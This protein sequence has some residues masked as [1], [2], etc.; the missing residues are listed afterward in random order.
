[1]NLKSL[2]MKFLSV[3]VCVPAVA[4]TYNADFG[5]YKSG[6]IAGQTSNWTI[7]GGA[8]SDWQIGQVDGQVALRHVGEGEGVIY[9]NKYACS[10]D[11]ILT[12]KIRLGAEGIS[13][14]SGVVFGSDG[15]GADAYHQWRAYFADNGAVTSGF[16]TVTGRITDIIRGKWMSFRLERRG[17]NIRLDYS[18]L[19]KPDYSAFL[20]EGTLPPLKS[21]ATGATIG[22]LGVG[23][24]AFADISLSFPE[25]ITP[26]QASVELSSNNMRLTVDTRTGLPIQLVSMVPSPME[27]L[28]TKN[29]FVFYIA[30]K[31]GKTVDIARAKSGIQ[32]LGKLAFE[33]TPSDP[34]MQN[35]Y[36][37]SVTYSLE[38]NSIHCHAELTALKD[39]AG[40]HQIRFAFGL[41]PKDYDYLWYPGIPHD[42]TFA[43]TDGGFSKFNQNFG[44]VMDK[45]GTKNLFFGTLPADDIQKASDVP[46]AALVTPMTV[47]ER[48]ERLVA[49]AHFDVGQPFLLA[50]DAAGGRG[51]YPMIL[52]FP[53]NIA[54]GQ[55]FVFDI[56]V[57]TFERPKK[58]Y[59]QVMRW[60]LENAY[61]TNPN[62]KDV[63]GLGKIK[64]GA[65]AMPSGLNCSG[66]NGQ[67]LATGMML[68]H[69]KDMIE[70]GMAMPFW[71]CGMST[72]DELYPLDSRPY[73]DEIGIRWTKEEVRTEIKRISDAGM[74][75][76][77]YRRSWLIWETCKDDRIPYKK[78]TLNPE[79]DPAKRAIEI[80]KLTPDEVKVYGFDTVH[81]VQA[82]FSNNDF[83]SWYV[84]QVIKELGYY[85]P[86][87]IWWDM[88]DSGQ[89]GVMDAMT[90]IRNK[91]A[92][93]YPWMRFVGNERA[94]TVDGLQCDAMAVESYEISGKTERTFQCAKAFGRSVYNLIYSVYYQM[95]GFILPKENYHSDVVVVNDVTYFAITYRTSSL[96]TKRDT[97]IITARQIS[98][99]DG[100]PAILVSAKDLKADGKWHTLYVPVAGKLSGAPR[101]N[102]IA[103]G[104]EDKMKAKDEK[105][106][107]VALFVN[108]PAGC[109]LD[110]S[111]YGFYASKPA[112]GDLASPRGANS[113][114]YDN[115]KSL[116]NWQTPQPVISK[117]GYARFSA[118]DKQDGTWIKTDFRP[119]YRGFAR[120]L[121]LGA[122]PGHGPAE[123]NFSMLHPLYDFSN[124]AS[125][126][127][128]VL[129]PMAAWPASAGVKAS[130]WAGRHRI[131][132]AAYNTDRTPV[133]VSIDIDLPLL[134][135]SYGFT[136]KMD[137][138]S[139]SIFNADLGTRAAQGFSIRRSDDGHATVTGRLGSNELMLLYAR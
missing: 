89:S 46:W 51:T 4:G 50:M 125:K 25:P 36:K 49:F 32:D 131:L 10:G 17:Q 82:D 85:Q 79:V 110:V 73:F 43:P 42:N 44:P 124:V 108:L 114:A 2:S 37:A 65:R 121:A 60:F 116:L 14:Y 129:E 122:F 123:P 35:T 105:A 55:S 128:V 9:W 62:T 31:S 99:R 16:G 74:H 39:L 97:P 107:V 23:D 20:L 38:A 78:W 64:V 8:D 34:L 48:S 81:K 19:G 92:E 18:P 90:Q 6:N 95:P 66:P 106:F 138:E 133:D 112:D 29:P 132:A 117:E 139:L 103:V 127:K 102:D 22:L 91:A 109:E 136:G 47:A 77:M 68:P 12:G 84:D 137:L 93:L 33:L 80:Q 67:K 134:A 113:M 87:G 96:D 76:L 130:V 86:A 75:P 111:A 11:F 120:G 28:E 45:Q 58:S 7:S 70:S 98:W 26:A 63:V 115:F 5:T 72:C 61:S 53:R 101:V 59:T 41:K 3:C 119:L 56:N 13:P 40:E 94:F 30:D 126:L 83:R 88:G 24:T 104:H 15:K 69:E 1:M 27:L 52:R 21:D 71:I 100:T 54:K 118:L 57:K 135:S